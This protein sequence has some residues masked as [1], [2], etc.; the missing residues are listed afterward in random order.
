MMLAESIDGATGVSH[1]NLVMQAAAV[2]SMYFFASGCVYGT[3][4]LQIW[5]LEMVWATDP[6]RR[7]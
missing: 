4:A 6:L 2:C 7:A 5:R 3:A 1:Q